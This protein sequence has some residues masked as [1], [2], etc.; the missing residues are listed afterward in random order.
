MAEP[1]IKISQIQQPYDLEGTITIFSK[2]WK[3]RYVIFKNNKLYCFDKKNSKKPMKETI[4]ITKDTVIIEE[5]NEKEKKEIFKFKTNHHELIVL[6]DDIVS[7]LQ[8][9]VIMLKTEHE[10][11]MK[12]LEE[13][14]LKTKQQHTAMTWEAIQEKISNYTT[15][16]KYS[17]D[18]ELKTTTLKSLFKEMGKDTFYRYMIQILQLTV[19]N[20]TAT[21]FV[22]FFYKEFCEED[23]EELGNFLGKKNEEKNEIEFVFGN[24]E[25]GAHKIAEIYHL[26][27]TKYHLV[28]SELARCLLVSIALWGIKSDT[29]MFQIITLDMFQHFSMA[30][31]VTFLHFYSDYE[32]ETETKKW[33]DIPDHIVVYMKKV[34]NGYSKE[35]LAAFISMITTMWNWDSENINR[36]MDAL[37]N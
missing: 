3:K 12:K 29:E 10:N 21:E 5:M 24:D 18:F 25:K 33:Y 2:H 26:I 20:F 15:T 9:R 11:Q 13:E 7:Q 34:T 37:M 30:E 1:E 6:K 17:D 36:L 16:M 32:N 28:W 14:K 31:I 23:L 27:Y 19:D 35:Q 8:Q 4:D 22:D